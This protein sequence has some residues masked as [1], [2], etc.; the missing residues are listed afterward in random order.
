MKRLAP[1]PCLRV[2]RGFALAA[3]AERGFHC[4]Y[5]CA[6]QSPFSERFIAAY[7]KTHPQNPC[8]R[9]FT[10]KGLLYTRT[11]HLPCRAAAVLAYLPRLSSLR[12][13]PSFRPLGRHR[14]HAL[15]GTSTAYRCCPAGENPLEGAEK[16]SLRC[17]RTS[18]KNAWTTVS[19]LHLPRAPH[20]LLCPSPFRPIVAVDVWL[21][22]PHPGLLIAAFAVRR[23]YGRRARLVSSRTAIKAGKFHVATGQVLDRRTSCG[24]APRD[25]VSGVQEQ[26]SILCVARTLV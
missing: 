17:R 6:H 13:P 25:F 14:T 2:P 26:V 11:A 7:T 20:P 15:P 9:V 22:D 5:R 19:P 3:A 8:L 10:A 23:P 21:A 16:A 18:E 24:I 4:Q 1:A 12:R